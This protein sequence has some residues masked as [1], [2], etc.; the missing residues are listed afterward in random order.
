MT[1]LTSSKTDFK[2]IRKST[3]RYFVMIKGSVH[4]ENITILEVYLLNNRASKYI[5]QNLT[6]L[7]EKQ[8]TPQ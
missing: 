6:E 7:K 4:Q 2:T 8:T 1:L 5:K 3:E